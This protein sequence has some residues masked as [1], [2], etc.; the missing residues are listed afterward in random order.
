[1]TTGYKVTVIGNPEIHI[2]TSQIPAFRKDE[3][4]RGALLLV[5]H[6]FSLPGA[7]EKFQAWRAKR[8]ANAERGDL[9]TPRRT[10]KINAPSGVETT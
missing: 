10:D 2:D 5:D 4:A 8:R 3:L 7:E 1:M 9:P 6:V